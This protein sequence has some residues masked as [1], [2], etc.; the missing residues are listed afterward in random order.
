MN[1]PN[2]FDEAS[3]NVKKNFGSVNTLCGCESL[4][5]NC[6]N[7]RPYQQGNITSQRDQCSNGLKKPRILLSSLA[8]L[9]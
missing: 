2:Q 8:L 9:L 1:S 4:K 5:Q 6:I 3:G 7:P